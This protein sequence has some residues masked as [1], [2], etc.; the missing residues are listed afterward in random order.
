MF[1]TDEDLAETIDKLD[2]V[3]LIFYSLEACAKILSLGLY[4][5]FDDNWN[6]FDFILI[7]VSFFFQIFIFDNLPIG[8][9]RTASRLTRVKY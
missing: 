6:C 1:T 4:T 5:Y 2:I 7:C 9:I 8:L 3:F